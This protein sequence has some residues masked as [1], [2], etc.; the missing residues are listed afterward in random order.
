MQQCLLQ[1]YLAQKYSLHAKKSN[2]FLGKKTGCTLTVD[3][4]NMEEEETNKK[5]KNQV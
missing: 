4:I 1:N 5:T 2:T 3:V